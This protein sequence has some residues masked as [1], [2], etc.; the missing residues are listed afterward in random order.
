MGDIVADNINRKAA[1]IELYLPDTII[2]DDEKLYP[3]EWESRKRIKNIE[4]VEE[5]LY[6][7]VISH[8]NDIKHSFHEVRNRIENGEVLFQAEEWKNM[9]ILLETIIFSFT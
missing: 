4:G 7:G 9:R 1:S 3:I 8:K 6:Q 2:S 5:A